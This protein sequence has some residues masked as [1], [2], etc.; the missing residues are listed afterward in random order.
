MKLPD[1]FFYQEAKTSTNYL[2]KN[3]KVRA[4][5]NEQIILCVGKLRGRYIQFQFFITFLSN[6]L[7]PK[8]IEYRTLE[9]LL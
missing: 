1:F 2:Y 3:K 7:Y 6:N 5:I 4:M 9:V 8:T